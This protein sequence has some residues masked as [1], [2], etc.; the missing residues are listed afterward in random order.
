MGDERPDAIQRGAGNEGKGDCVQMNE[1][2]CATCANQNND[3]KKCRTM[4]K[5][6][7]DY[8]CWGNAEMVKKR[9]D[10]IKA[11]SDKTGKRIGS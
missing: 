6:F 3:G 1:R 4:L 9:E 2:K 10:E 5:P 11:Y 8:S 7:S